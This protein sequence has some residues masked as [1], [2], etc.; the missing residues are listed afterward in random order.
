MI[1]KMRKASYGMLVI[2][3]ILGVAGYALAGA[4]MQVVGTVGEDNT[5]T[6]ESGM[7][8]EIGDNEKGEEIS[9]LAGKKVE[10]MGKV[11][12]EGGSKIIMIDSFKLL[13]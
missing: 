1:R 8:Y 11:E 10:I 2:F 7:V 13:K 6:D 9:E 3:L 4:D 12:E 5:I